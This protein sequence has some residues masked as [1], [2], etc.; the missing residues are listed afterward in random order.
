MYS[1]E[2]QIER[3]SNAYDRAMNENSL[4]G[5]YCTEQE[6]LADERAAAE[7]FNEN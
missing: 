4:G 6:Y 5:M 3:L 7:W 2:I 1:D